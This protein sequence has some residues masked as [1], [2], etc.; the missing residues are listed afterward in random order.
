MIPPTSRGAQINP[1]MGTS[2][3][4]VGRDNGQAT[5]LSAVT[6]WSSAELRRN[7]FNHLILP[8]KGH[9][10]TSVRPGRGKKIFA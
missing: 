10:L 7:S 2:D 5:Q 6:L 8:M 9:A 4:R 3:R 1:Q